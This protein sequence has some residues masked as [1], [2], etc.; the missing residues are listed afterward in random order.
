M[1]KAIRITKENRNAV[2]DQFGLD[3]GYLDYSSGLYLVAKF[4]HTMHEGLLTKK[5]F[6]EKY[7]ETG[8]TLDNGFVEIVPAVAGG[9]AN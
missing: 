1:M 2:T 6:A 3:S 5:S 8:K 9:V 7:D 4:G